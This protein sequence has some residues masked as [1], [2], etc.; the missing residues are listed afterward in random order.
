MLYDIFNGSVFYT[1]VVSI[2]SNVTIQNVKWAII[3]FKFFYLANILF[4]NVQWAH[5]KYPVIESSI[6]KCLVII[7]TMHINIHE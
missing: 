1:N 4:D 3:P 6:H 7:I 2:K 5:T